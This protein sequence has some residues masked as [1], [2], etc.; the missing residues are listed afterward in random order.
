MRLSKR[1]QVL[2]DVAERLTTQPISVGP[3][4]LDRLR[5]AGFD[6]P[7]ALEVLEIAAFFNYA[8]RLTLALNIVPDEQFFAH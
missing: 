6:E 2:A 8:N 4:E 3:S 1:E 5:Q 7:A